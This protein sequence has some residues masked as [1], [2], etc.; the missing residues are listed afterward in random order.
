[1]RPRI[2][3]SAML[4]DLLGRPVWVLKTDRFEIVRSSWKDINYALQRLLSDQERWM[5]DPEDWMAN[6]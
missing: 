5:G 3:K 6:K 4:G 1:M 2:Y